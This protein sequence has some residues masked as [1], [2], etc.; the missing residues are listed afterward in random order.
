MRY[1]EYYERVD[2]LFEMVKCMRGKSTAFLDPV[3]FFHNIKAHN[4]AFLQSNMNAFN[5]F[6]HSFNVYISCADL[7][8]MPCFTYHPVKRKEQSQ[9]FNAHFQ[10]YLIGYDFFIDLDGESYEDAK[11]LKWFLDKH[12]APYYVTCSGTGFHF[13]IPS[14]Y[15]AGMFPDFNERLKS[16]RKFA[17]SLKSLLELSSLDISVYDLRRVRKCPYS[18]DT[19]TGR[20]V[21][22]LTDE[23]FNNF[24]YRMI[25]DFNISFKNRGLLIRNEN[26]TLATMKMFKD[27][28][29]L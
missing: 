2:V 13:I 5:F 11:K 29:V 23:Q 6:K 15:F 17:S 26:N 12:K 25:E 19:K 4:V 3:Y 18:M 20:I 14:I 24:N 8:N 16:F 7:L 22:P 27:M 28:E 21:M 9:N 10:D 1:Q